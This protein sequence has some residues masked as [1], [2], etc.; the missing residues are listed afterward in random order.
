M[1]NDGVGEKWIA[2][3]T[4]IYIKSYIAIVSMNLSHYIV[5]LFI[6]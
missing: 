4:D 3:L 1:Q 6:H 2:D 5:C